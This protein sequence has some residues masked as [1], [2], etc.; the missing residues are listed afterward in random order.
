M[1]YLF[2]SPDSQSVCVITSEVGLLEAACAQILFL[3]T[4]SQSVSFGWSNYLFAFNVII[5]MCAPIAIF[6]NCLGFC[7][8]VSSLVFPAREFPLA[9]VVRLIWWC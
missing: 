5:D 1:E 7:G 8:S 9:F 3:Y 4:F 2:L 6:L